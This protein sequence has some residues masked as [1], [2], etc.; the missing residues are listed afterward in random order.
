MGFGRVLF[1]SLLEPAAAAAGAS[2]V[3]WC[4]VV[5]QWSSY[6]LPYTYAVVHAC[7]FGLVTLELLLAFLASSSRPVN[8]S[9]RFLA[10]AGL[11]A[12]LTTLAK[13]EMGLVAVATGLLAVAIAGWTQPR[14]MLGH[15]ARFLLPAVI[16][17]SIDRKSTRLNSSHI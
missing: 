9:P 11:S 1:R 7:L 2:I 12:G 5:N 15:A 10:L 3:I 8:G 14:R 13:T 4:F 17:V 16:L 6:I